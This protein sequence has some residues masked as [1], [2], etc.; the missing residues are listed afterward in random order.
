[1]AYL[2]RENQKDFY[3]SFYKYFII[4]KF[5]INLKECIS[6]HQGTSQSQMASRT[7]V[8]M[9]ACSSGPAGSL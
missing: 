6:L 2:P 8:L 7:F 4:Y 9:S 5:Y 1:M 3:V